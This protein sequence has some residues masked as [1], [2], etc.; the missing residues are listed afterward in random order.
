MIAHGLG[1]PAVVDCRD[2]TELLKDGTLVTV[3]CAEGD[4]SK[5]YDGPL[6]TDITEVARRVLSALP[7]TMARSR[8][9]TSNF[10]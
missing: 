10:S 3:S 5:I 2:A 8:T 1:V 6:E 4:E 7:G 9:C